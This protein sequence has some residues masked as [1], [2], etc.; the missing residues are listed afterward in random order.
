MDSTRHA[1]YE[2]GVKGFGLA[3][4]LVKT[5]GAAAAVENLD[6]YSLTLTAFQLKPPAYLAALRLASRQAS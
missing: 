3:A 5:A 6:Q 4:A 2:F 1:G